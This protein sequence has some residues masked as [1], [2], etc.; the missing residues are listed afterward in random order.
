MVLV[1]LVEE[2]VDLVQPWVAMELPILAGA[3]GVLALEALVL[4][5]L[6]WQEL[7]IGHKEEKWRILQR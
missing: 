1:L 3:A 2:M 7:P 6:G 4:E 5:A